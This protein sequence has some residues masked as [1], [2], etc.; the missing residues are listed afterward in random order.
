MEPRLDPQPEAAR[1]TIFAGLIRY[2]ESFLG[3]S[4]FTPLV[5]AARE[6]EGAVVAGATGRVYQGWLMIE[7]VWVHED[8]RRAGLGSRVLR[9]IEREG[10]THGAMRAFLDTFAFQAAPFYEKQG[11][12]EVA[13]IPRFF[14]DYD[15]I[16]LEKDLL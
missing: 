7:M 13:R 9:E 8:H 14:G 16:Y 11:Y 3:P 2:N 6:D 12:R 4:N 5:V 1:A 10:Q 15:R